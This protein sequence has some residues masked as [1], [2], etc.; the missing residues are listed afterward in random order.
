[1]DQHR[2]SM[3]AEKSADIHTLAPRLSYVEDLAAWLKDNRGGGSDP[4]EL[5]KKLYRQVV[6]GAEPGAINADV[7]NQDT[8]YTDPLGEKSMHITLFGLGSTNATAC[9]WNGKGLYAWIFA[10]GETRWSVDG[11]SYNL[12]ADVFG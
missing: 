1:M 8:A 12:S 5:L 6:W 10:Q 4:S 9:Q 11:S 2:R 7:W 3:M